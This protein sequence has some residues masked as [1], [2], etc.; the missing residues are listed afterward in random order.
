MTV[1]ITVFWDV[2]LCIL[3]N[4]CQGFVDIM[5]HKTEVLIFV[6]RTSGLI[7]IYRK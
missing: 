7:Q 3:A 6:V 2:M 4:G 1:K 5:S